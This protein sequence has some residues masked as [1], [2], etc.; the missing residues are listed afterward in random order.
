MCRHP[1]FKEVANGNDIMLLKVSIH[2]FSLGFTKDI[3]RSYE[4]INNKNS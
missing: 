4:S 2:L 3:R 1:A